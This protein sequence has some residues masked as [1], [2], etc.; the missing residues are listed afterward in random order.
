MAGEPAAAFT[1][2]NPGGGSASSAGAAT[3]GDPH[4]V[5]QR[6]RFGGA[7]V[8]EP[9][10]LDMCEETASSVSTIGDDS[11]KRRPSRGGGGRSASLLNRPVGQIPFADEVGES[12]YLFAQAADLFAH[13]HAQTADLF[14]HLHA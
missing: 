7:L 8:H 13:L 9:D 4:P 3:T 1:R 6:G 12:A 5:E 2:P 10:V 14:A 11:V